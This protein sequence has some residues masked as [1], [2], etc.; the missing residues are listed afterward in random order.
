M[1]NKLKTFCIIGDPIE[2]SLSPLM[3]NSAF[4]EMKLNSTYIAFRVAKD[5]LKD[6]VAS[7][8]STR[9]HWF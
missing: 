5:D 4:K 3:Q 8:K 2:H 7:L 6:S 9:Y 1:S